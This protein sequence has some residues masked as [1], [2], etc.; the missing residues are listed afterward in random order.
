MP[1]KLSSTLG[2][3]QVCPIATRN[4]M[5]VQR[6]GN[7]SGPEEEEIVGV[8][9]FKFWNSS[10]KEIYF[11]LAVILY[12]ISSVRFKLFAFA[13]FNFSLSVRLSGQFCLVK[14]IY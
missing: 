6:E 3:L 5:S 8:S 7:L 12:I 14:Q 9:E 2:Q 4:P 11:H 10:I 1:V 13:G